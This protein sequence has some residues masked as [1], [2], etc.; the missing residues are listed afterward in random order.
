MRHTGKP[1]D[2]DGQW[3]ARGQVL[4]TLLEHLIASEPWFR[5]PTPKSTG[6]DLFNM[7]W[8]EDRLASFDGSRPSA[9]DVQATLQRLTARTVSNAMEA[10]APAT[11]GGGAHNIAVC[12]KNWRTACNAL[13]IPPTR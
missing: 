13:F 10:S 8:L 11:Q 7:S 3:A 4:P 5:L 1:Y 12:L 6:R 2:A 9:A